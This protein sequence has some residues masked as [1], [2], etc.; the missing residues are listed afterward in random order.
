MFCKSCG[1]KINDNAKFCPNCG[2]KK[3]SDILSSI[4]E[5]ADES[6][7]NPLCIAGIVLTVLMFFFNYQGLIGYAAVIVSAIGLW[8]A[9]ERSQKGLMLAVVS[10]IISGV[11]SFIHIKAVIDY[12]NYVAEQDA[13]AEGLLNWLGGFFQ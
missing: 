13:V 5:N 12:N 7:I 10:M 9:K 11:F 4:V 1:K 6:Q 8:Q 3:D 2:E